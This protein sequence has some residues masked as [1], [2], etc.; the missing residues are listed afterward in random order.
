MAAAPNRL[1]VADLTYVST[2]TGF[3][4]VAFVVDAFSRRIVGWRV[5]ASLSERID[6]PER[7]T[8]RARAI[9]LPPTCAQRRL[10]SL[11]AGLDADEPAVLDLIDGYGI[12]AETIVA[13]GAKVVGAGGEGEALDGL[14]TRLSV[15]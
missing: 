7:R 5:S 15:L 8:R 13:A 11:D 6:L 4:Y 10:L 2:W 12:E 9:R 1:W 14:Q 3:C